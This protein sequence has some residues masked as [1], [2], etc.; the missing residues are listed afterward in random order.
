MFGRNEILIGAGN[1]QGNFSVADMKSIRGDLVQRVFYVTTADGVE[2]EISA[3]NLMAILINYKNWT[4][5]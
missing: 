4:P 5:I 2:H 3:E 1:E